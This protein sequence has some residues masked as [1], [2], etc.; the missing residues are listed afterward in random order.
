[1]GDGKVGVAADILPPLAK[2]VED[3]TKSVITRAIQFN[4][5]VT[6]KKAK[7]LG[8][9]KVMTCTDENIE[10]WEHLPVELGDEIYQ[11]VEGLD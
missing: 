8:L 4:D 2:R 11:L 3:F 6:I 5:S 1:M 7:E 9:V 10:H